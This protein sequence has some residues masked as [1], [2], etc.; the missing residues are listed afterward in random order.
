MKKLCC[1]FLVLLS[2]S[3]G[4]DI[5]VDVDLPEEIETPGE[6][7]GQGTELARYHADETDYK[8]DGKV[9]RKKSDNLPL[10]GTVFYHYNNGQLAYER[11]YQNGLLDG[12]SRSW[13]ENGQ[14]SSEG[15]LKQDQLHGLVR[16]WFPDGG[17]EYE[18]SYEMGNCVRGCP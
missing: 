10:T 8:K 3:C 14:L 17:L 12:P 5:P 16:A 4:D 11:S 15:T 2:F 7:K 6:K 13:Y 9:L 18:R 1:L